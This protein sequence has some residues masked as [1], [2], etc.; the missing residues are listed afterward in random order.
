M[1]LADADFAF[2]D[3]LVDSGQSTLT[4]RIW[5][6]IAGQLRM[7][8]ALSDPLYLREDGDVAESHQRIMDAL[9]T[10][11]AVALERALREHLSNVRPLLAQLEQA[12]EEG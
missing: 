10:R 6:S 9:R 5:R 7:S 11:D 4:R 12:T 1:R 8:L 3:T 2:H